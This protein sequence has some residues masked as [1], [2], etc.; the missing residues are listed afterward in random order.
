[1]FEIFVGAGDGV[2]A[3]LQLPATDEDA[4]VGIGRRAEF[5]AQDEIFWEILRGGQLLNP[6]PLGRS[7]DDQPAI[8]GDKSTVSAARLAVEADRV[9]DNGPRRGLWIAGLPFSGGF[10]VGV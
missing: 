1:M 9:C 5:Q 7:H 6:A 8:P 2:I 10:L 3:A 4:A